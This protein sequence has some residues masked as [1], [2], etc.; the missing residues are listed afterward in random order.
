M[1]LTPVLLIG[2]T[3]VLA[4]ANG[5]NDVSKGIAT[6]VGSGVTNYRQAVQWGAV[7]TVAGGMAAA[8]ASRGLVAVF[9]GK[10]LLAADPAGPFFLTAVAIGAIGWLAVAIRTG[11]PV[12]TTHALVGGLVGAGIAAQGVGGVQWAAVATKTAIPL[13]VSPLIA[14]G[15]VIG[16]YPAIGFAFRRFNRYCVCVERA[17]P[18]VLAGGSAA[19]LTAGPAVRV[20]AGADCSTS[21][22]AR[23]NAMDSMHWLTSGATSFFRGMND[24][25]KILA[26]GVVAAAGSGLAVEWLF[27][28]VALAMGVGSYLAGRRVTDTLAGKVTTIGHD[29]GF[30]AN[31]VTSALVG[32]SSFYAL[33]VSTTHV[34]T[35]A[36]TGVG[37]RQGTVRWRM[38]RDLAL[39]W[40]V[41]LPATGMLAALAYL[42]LVNLG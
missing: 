17:E 16:S 1:L 5:A 12:S 20:I 22:V 15:L 28:L 34:S 42:A 2:L 26:L 23:V 21:V 36:I 7:W 6:L 37:T 35:G 25:P 18:V 9:S 32:V 10:G 11:M 39:A 31:L 38:V 3:L 29:D 41:T 14:L 13:A 33:P 4:F 8:V 30:T 27:A 24:T 40:V 19:A